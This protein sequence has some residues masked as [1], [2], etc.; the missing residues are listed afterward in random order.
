M[1]FANLL[2]LVKK[3]IVHFIRT[4]SV[5]HRFIQF[6]EIVDVVIIRR[7]KIERYYLFFFNPVRKQFLF[8]KVK[9]R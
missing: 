9:K 4:K 7:F 5:F 6:S 3:N 2:N 1:K 8:E